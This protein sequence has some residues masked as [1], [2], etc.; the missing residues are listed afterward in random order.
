MKPL[1]NC[2]RVR[3]VCDDESPESL[4]AVPAPSHRH[5][6]RGGAP[7][8]LKRFCASLAFH[9]ARN[10]RGRSRRHLDPG[11]RGVELRPQRRHRSR[12]PR[13][14]TGF[15][16]TDCRFSLSNGV[17]DPLSAAKRRLYVGRALPEE[18]ARTVP[19]ISASK[20]P[21]TRIIVAGAGT[22]VGLWTRVRKVFSKVLKAAELPAHL[23]PHS[24]RHS[25]ASLLLQQGE[26]PQ[27]VQEQL[28]HSSITLTVDLYG[29]WL[30]KLPIRGGVNALDEDSGSKVVAKIKSGTPDASE[31][32]D[33]NGGPSRTRTLDPLIKSQLLYQL[34]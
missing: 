1:S 2:L 29:R 6:G 3:G 14:C 19:H 4:R 16:Q 5:P 12:R 11:L 30:P 21:A 20:P 33:L 32:P 7:V 15:Q 24:L 27:Y 26:S 25:F 17:A 23:S 34:S 9:R 8:P 31:A 22:E 18:C 13:H 28:G 10:G